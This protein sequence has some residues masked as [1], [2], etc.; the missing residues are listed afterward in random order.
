[1]SVFC[2]LA[3]LINFLVGL[4]L[5]YDFL[6]II[7]IPFLQCLYP[8]LQNVVFLLHCLN[9]SIESDMAVAKLHV[10]YSQLVNLL[11]HDRGGLH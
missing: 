6:A 3:R 5:C 10:F 11:F 9:F 2:H 7:S 4:Q 1:M 8:Q